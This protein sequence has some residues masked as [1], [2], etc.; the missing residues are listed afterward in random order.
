MYAIHD[1][2]VKH[3]PPYV[4]GVLAAKVRI[5]AHCMLT[6]W[7]RSILGHPFFPKGQPRREH[8]KQNIWCRCLKVPFASNTQRNPCSECPSPWRWLT[9]QLQS[10]QPQKLAVLIVNAFLMRRIPPWLYMCEAQSVVHESLQQYAVN[11][12]NASC[13]SNKPNARH[14]SY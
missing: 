6:S 5:K 13:R 7:R 4:A 3:H 11:S 14:K 10:F 2:E 12:L 8:L 1:S 9:A